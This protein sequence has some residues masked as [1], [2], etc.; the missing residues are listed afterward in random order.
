MTVI[1][2]NSPKSKKIIHSWRYSIFVVKEFAGLD[3]AYSR[4]TQSTKTTHNRLRLRIVDQEIRI[5]NQEYAESTKSKWSQTVI[6]TIFEL[7]EWGGGGRV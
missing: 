5:V 4:N 7:F 3:T 2:T 6:S 1:E